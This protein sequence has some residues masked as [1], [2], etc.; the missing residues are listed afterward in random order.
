MRTENAGQTGRPPETA[1]VTFKFHIPLEPRCETATANGSREA[2]LNCKSK[3]QKYLAKQIGRRKERRGWEEGSRGGECENAD[4]VS[5]YA[6][7]PLKVP[8]KLQPKL[9][10]IC[11]AKKGPRSEVPWLAA[12]PS[13]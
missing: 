1:T 2:Y 13:P 6:A 5:S 9:E 8:L 7:V 11:R 12:S 10:P 3:A 4:F